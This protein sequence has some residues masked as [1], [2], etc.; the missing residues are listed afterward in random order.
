MSRERT[1]A[2]TLIE[3]L[4]VIGVIA[5]LVALLLPALSAARRQAAQVKCAAG[6]KQLGGAFALYAHDNDGYFPVARWQIPAGAA[7]EPGID[8]LYWSDFI[9]PYAARHARFNRWLVLNPAGLAAARQTVVW[10]CPNWDGISAAAGSGFNVDG[11]SA[12]ENGY[13]MNPYPTYDTLHPANPAQ[14]VPSSQ[15]AVVAAS[16]G[17]NGQFFKQ[18]KWTR[19]AERALLV[20][21]TLWLLGFNPVASP[22]DPVAPQRVE[23][24]PSSVAGDLTIDRYRHGRHPRVTGA[25]YDPAGGRV[26]FNV[27]FADGHIET[28]PSAAA[29]YRAIRLREP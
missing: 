3:L 5:I 24:G 20:E 25:V 27:A 6:M 18:T 9:A 11:I 15:T 22:G 10:G 29:G 21:S 17:Q 23:R 16:S 2:F 8:N 19:P 28:L 7:A 26:A 14:S 1:R 13:T 12:Y 4:V